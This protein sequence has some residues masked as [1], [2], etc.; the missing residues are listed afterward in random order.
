M[1]ITFDKLKNIISESWEDYAS[2]SETLDEIL[3]EMRDLAKKHTYGDE[4]SDSLAEI[5]ID[6]Y[7]D[8]IE[9]AVKRMLLHG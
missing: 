8:R 4:V 7:A 6:D 5:P 3:K 9:A 1:K 2:D